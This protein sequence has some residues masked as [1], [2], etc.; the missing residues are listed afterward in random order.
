VKYPVTAAPTL[1]IYYFHGLHRCPTCL[2]IERETKA[3]LQHEL[4]ELAKSRKVSLEIFT[5]EEAKNQ[6]L[7]KKYDIWGSS[8]LIVDDKGNKVADLTEE[9]FS[10]ARTRPEEFRKILADKVQALLKQ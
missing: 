6:Q 9:G 8:L 5:I 1:K 7:V 10:K 2:A 3:A 4:K